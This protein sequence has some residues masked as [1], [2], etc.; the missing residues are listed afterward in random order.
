MPKTEIT[1]FIS[2]QRTRSHFH[3]AILLAGTGMVLAATL[4]WDLFLEQELAP[5]K[6]LHYKAGRIIASCV[7]YLAYIC[8]ISRV[9]LMRKGG[10]TSL[11]LALLW[12]PAL[13]VVCICLAIGIAFI[14]GTGKEIYDVSGYGLFDTLD[15]D[16]TMDGAMS[17]VM[18]VAV[19]IAFTPLLIPL[20]ILM[21]VPRLMVSDVRSGIAGLD[22]YVSAVKKLKQSGKT[23]SV[24]LVEDDIFSATTVLHFCQNTGLSCRHVTTVSEADDYLR[25]NPERIRLVVLDNFLGVD[26]QG[27]NTTGSQW[28][29]Q[30][31]A[32][33]PKKNRSFLIAFISGHTEMLD[34]QT[35]ALADI[36]L[37]KPW[38]PVKLKEM[39]M[40]KGLI[41]ER[42][43][44]L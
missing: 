40:N 1:D 17:M 14:F 27:R 26:A 20:D 35:T 4:G 16:A 25:D 9:L 36:V 33:F 32:E 12:I 39:L 42:G 10:G 30:L 6:V 15:I 23:L 24:L 7:F 8:I 18:P 21:Q 28:L 41:A 37:Q 2:R 11:T 31:S 38:S 43:M 13:I 3:A 19:I 29:Q 34:R 22:E 5:D 44:N